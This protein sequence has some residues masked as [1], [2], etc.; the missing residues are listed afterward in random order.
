MTGCEFFCK[1]IVGRENPCDA[2]QPSVFTPPITISLPYP[3]KKSHAKKF[4]S[5]SP[6]RYTTT[7]FFMHTPR[8]NSKAATFFP[9][10]SKKYNTFYIL[11]KSSASFNSDTASALS[12]SKFILRPPCFCTVFLL[13]ETHF[14]AIIIRHESN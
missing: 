7:H 14:C 8:K 10:V 12:Y 2:N 6:S 11:K 4:L 3:T 1:K 13:R 5:P 9:P